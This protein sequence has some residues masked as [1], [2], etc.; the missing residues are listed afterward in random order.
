MLVDGTSAAGGVAVDM[1]RHRRLLLRPAEGV[2]RRGAGCGSR[3]C[4][5]PPSSGRPRCAPSGGRRRPSTSVSR[6]TTRPRTRPTTLP[7]S[8]RCGCSRT[9]SSGC[10][11]RAG[12]PGPPTGYSRLRPAALPLGRG[13]GLRDAVRHRSGA[14]QPGRRDDR[15]RRRGRRARRSPRP[16]APTASSTPSPTG[17]WDATSCGSAC[18][19]RSTRRRQRADRVHRPRGGRA[20]LRRRVLP[21]IGCAGTYRLAM[22]D[23]AP[24]RERQRGRRVVV[25]RR[26]TGWRSSNCRSTRHCAPRCSRGARRRPSPQAKSAAAAPAT[27]AITPREIQ[28][29]VRAGEPPQSN[30]PRTSAPTSTGCCG[31]RHRCSPSA[32]GSPTRAAAARHAARPPRARSSCSARPSTSGSPPT[33]STRGRC[34]GTPTG[35]RTASGSWPRTGSAGRPSAPPSGPSIW[36]RAPS[37]RSTTPRPTCSATVRSVRW[38][39]PEPDAARAVALTSRRRRRTHRPGRRS[40]PCRTRTPARCRAAEEVFDQAEASRN[41]TCR[42]T[43]RIRAVQPA[44]PPSTDLGRRPA[45]GR[46]RGRQGRPRVHPVLGRHPARRPPQGD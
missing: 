22:R 35:A 30:S 21:A 2:R 24:R 6:W 23:A 16:C 45:R 1:R 32:S 13:V 20:R 3:C 18:T 33:A 12:S 28:M 40:R 42:C 26:P 25:S 7:P 17:R 41:R 39:A 9:R 43:S 29:R 38:P 46:I 14:A 36:R 4:R 34:A 44:E 8:P 37:P 31:S 19:R 27:P 10:S 15:P 5:P 11:P